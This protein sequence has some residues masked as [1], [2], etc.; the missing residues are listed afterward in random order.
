[1]S[2]LLLPR[3]GYLRYI[4]SRI[5]TNSEEIAFYGG[6]D[7]EH[8]AL[9]KAYTRLTQQSGK[10]YSQ[11]L[12]YVMLE[13]FLMKYGWA[14][15]FIVRNEKRR[16]QCQSLIG[17]AGSGMVVTAIPILTATALSQSGDENSVSDRT[18]YY[19]TAK[20]LLVSGGDAMERLMTAYKVRGVHFQETTF[21]KKGTGFPGNC[22][23][24]WIHVQGGSDDGRL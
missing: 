20:N 22:G 3:K 11:K 2:W 16:V 21:R 14:G 10:I 6:N 8:T 7:I 13:Q 17:T 24:C 15:E 18:E 4:H 1:M 5:I 23:T 12:W 19:T 9:Q